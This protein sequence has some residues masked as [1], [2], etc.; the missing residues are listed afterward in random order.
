VQNISTS[1]DYQLLEVELI[2]LS[3]Y[4][5]AESNEDT[6]IV[7]KLDAPVFRKCSNTK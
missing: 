5:D 6:E 3:D 1:Q 4:E 2:Y 7:I